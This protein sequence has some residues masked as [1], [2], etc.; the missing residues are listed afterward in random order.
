VPAFV[1]VTS[2]QRHIF[3]VVVADNHFSCGFAAAAAISSNLAV[4]N[5]SVDNSNGPRFFFN[6]TH[7]IPPQANESF[8]NLQHTNDCFAARIDD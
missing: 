2:E 3:V 8:A 1:T 4:K 7:G 5:I 6:R